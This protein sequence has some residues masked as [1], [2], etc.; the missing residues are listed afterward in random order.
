MFPLANPFRF[1]G[2]DVIDASA[3]FAGIVCNATCSE[4]AERRH[5]GLRRRGQRPIIGSQTGDH[6]AGGSGDDTILGLRGIDQIYGDSGFNVDIL[7][8]GLTIPTANAGFTTRERRSCCSSPAATC[9]GARARARS[10]RS[11]AA[12]RPATTT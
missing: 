11:G 2:N 8:R 9:S 10:A 3:L 1:A 6:L 5:H 4:P 7:T 12:R